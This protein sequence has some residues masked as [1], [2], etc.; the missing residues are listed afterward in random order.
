VAYGDSKSIDQ[1]DS[2]LLV[3]FQEKGLVGEKTNDDPLAV[4]CNLKWAKYHEKERMQCKHMIKATKE[5]A[6]KGVG[7]LCDPAQMSAL[8]VFTCTSHTRI[9]Q[10]TLVKDCRF[11]PSIT[12]T[13]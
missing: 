2:A 9:E 6:E 5:G 10:V 3:E 13:F 12:P 8:V 1:F 7:R 11:E 4:S